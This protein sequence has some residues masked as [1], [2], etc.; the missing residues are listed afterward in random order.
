MIS[1]QYLHLRFDQFFKAL[2]L[3][4]KQ[5]KLLND[6]KDIKAKRFFINEIVV[7][8]D[9]FTTRVKQDYELIENRQSFVNK[10]VF[11]RD[12]KWIEI[13]KF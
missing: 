3:F 5:Y 10:F 6:K 12:Y 9:E 8:V 7:Y 11:K 2:I 4:Y 13:I 1:K